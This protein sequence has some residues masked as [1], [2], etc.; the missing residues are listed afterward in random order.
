MNIFIYYF[1]TKVHKAI[2]AGKYFSAHTGKQL[3]ENMLCWAKLVG[4]EP[5]SQTIRDYHLKAAS[6]LS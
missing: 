1:L 2:Y 3:L 5:L 4:E 6:L